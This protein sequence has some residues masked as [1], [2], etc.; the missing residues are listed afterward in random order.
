MHFLPD[1]YVKCDHCEGKRYNNETLEIKYKAK[2][3]SDI[4]NMRVSEAVVFF[5]NNRKIKQ[6]LQTLMDVGLGYI[7]LGQAS[8]T[9]SGGEA[10]RVKLATFLQKKPT[11]KT[12]CVLDEPTTGL[13]QYDVKKLIDVLNRIVDG[14]DTVLVIEHN[15][16][17]IKVSDYV[18][19]MGP[20]GG[21]KGGKVVATG[22]PEQVSKISGSFTG[23]YLKEIL[24]K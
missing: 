18:I 5:E 7:Q 4:L 23:K 2:N 13:H 19:D 12:L 21:V 11:G 9:L 16:D 17:I 24:T 8:T 3:I 1:V 22:T 10:Q 15:L 20:G 14:G 6:K